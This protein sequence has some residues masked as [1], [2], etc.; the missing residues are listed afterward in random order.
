MTIVKVNV[1]LI[2]IEALSG[3]NI[4]ASGDRTKNASKAAN[5]Y[6]KLARLKEEFSTGV[7]AIAS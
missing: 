3:N 7:G 1:K 5:I 4:C 2:M 6:M